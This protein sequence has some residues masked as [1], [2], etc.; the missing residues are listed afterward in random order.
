MDR[1][2]RQVTA[3]VLQFYVEFEDG[4]LPRNTMMDLSRGEYFE[5]RIIDY[6]IDIE[7]VLK[8]LGDDNVSVIMAVHR[9]GLT[10]GDAMLSAGMDPASANRYV[11][12]LEVK[13]GKAF[14]RKN[15]L[16]FLQYIR[17]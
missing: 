14:E 3:S 5:P 16:D 15:L 17:R 11:A 6:R 13:L 4:M 8:T 2:F 10:H 12:A 9:D 1:Y 7:R